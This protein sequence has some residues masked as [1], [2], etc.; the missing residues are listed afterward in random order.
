MVT[1]DNCNSKLEEGSK[2]CPN[3]GNKIFETVFCPNCGEKSSSGFDFCEKCGA[4]MKAEEIEKTKLF[5]NKSLK[6]PTKL[7]I[8]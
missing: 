2:F 5:P 8:Q 6:N 7:R 3:C 4:S 1:C